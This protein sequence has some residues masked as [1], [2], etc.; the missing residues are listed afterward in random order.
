MSDINLLP[1][2]IRSQEKKT[3]TAGLLKL[4]A[5]AALVVSIVTTGVLLWLFISTKS[6]LDAVNKTISTT[7]MALAASKNTEDDLISLSAKSA[8]LTKLINARPLYSKFLDSLAKTLPADVKISEINILSPLKAGVSGDSLGYLSLSQLLK[9]INNGTSPVFSGATLN[10]V[11]LN[12]Q[13]GR[14]QF[15]MEITIK[16]KGLL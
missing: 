5:I 8:E 13:T 4:L 7:T 16:D 2:D 11:V 15:I 14:V 3:K 6:Q 1:H 10:S 9:T 12:S